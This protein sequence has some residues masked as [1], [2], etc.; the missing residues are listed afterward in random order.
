MP[1]RRA[2]RRKG[3]LRSCVWKVRYHWQRAAERAAAAASERSGDY[4]AAYGCRYCGGWHIGHPPKAKR[5]A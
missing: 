5:E 3:I 4:I 1:G 2:D